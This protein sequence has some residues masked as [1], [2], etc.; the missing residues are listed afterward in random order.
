MHVAEEAHQ[1]HAGCRF[2]VPKV[3]PAPSL[4][5]VARH[6]EQSVRGE[7]APERGDAVLPELRYVPSAKATSDASVADSSM[8]FVIHTCCTMHT[9]IP[10]LYVYLWARARDGVRVRDLSH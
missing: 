3:A 4:P 5:P 2:A 8:P 7:H 1:K 10:E 6:A 9:C